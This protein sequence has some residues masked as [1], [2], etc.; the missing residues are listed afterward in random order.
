MSLTHNQNHPLVCWSLKILLKY[1]KKKTIYVTI[2]PAIAVRK[3]HNPFLGSGPKGAMF[4]RMQGIFCPSIHP[5]L[6]RL[7]RGLGPGAW[8]GGAWAGGPGPGPR[9]LG[10]GQGAGP[11][12]Y[13]R[14]YGRTD[15]ISPTFYRTSPLWGRCPK[16]DQLLQQKQQ[17]Q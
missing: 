2:K 10:L 7:G 13:G 11:R 4:R 17:Q 1:T 8:P 6:T 3:S 12:G 5:A 9:G 15:K 16:R 14:T